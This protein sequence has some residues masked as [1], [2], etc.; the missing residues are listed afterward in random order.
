M[1][2]VDRACCEDLWPA[3]EAPLLKIQPGPVLRDRSPGARNCLALE[4]ALVCA[5]RNE[6]RRQWARMPLVAVAETMSAT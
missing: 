6:A 5:N 2:G 1:I 4:M 3:V